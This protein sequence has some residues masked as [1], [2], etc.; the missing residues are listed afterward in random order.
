MTDLKKFLEEN[1]E[2]IHDILNHMWQ[3]M[4]RIAIRLED[5]IPNI[6][7][8]N[9][10]GNFIELADGWAESYYANPS[11]VFPY[12]ELGYSLDGLFC[13]FSINTSKVQEKLLVK[14]TELS[15]DNESITYQIYGGDDCFTTL[16]HSKD[17][18]D[19]DVLLKSI[20]KSKEDILQLEIGIEAYPEEDIMGTFIDS[21]I[22][23][24]QFLEENEI[25]ERLPMY[26]I[27]E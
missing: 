3:T 18:E 17:S 2:E 5:V 12:G 6:D 16:Y 19:F 1:K 11:L 10:H 15:Q 25:L 22:S 26:E 13:V 9:S 4:E 7:L 27:E 14:I 23:L 24:Y 8:D 20:K 21:I